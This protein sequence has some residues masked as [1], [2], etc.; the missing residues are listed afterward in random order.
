[1]KKVP[2]GWGYSKINGKEIWTSPTKESQSTDE[3]DPIIEKG[4]DDKGNYYE[5]RKSDQKFLEPLDLELEARN[6]FKQ[7]REIASE[8]KMSDKYRNMIDQDFQEAHLTDSQQGEQAGIRSYNEQVDPVNQALKAGEPLRKFH[9]PEAQKQIDSDA[10]IY[11][12]TKPLEIGPKFE[13]PDLFLEFED[14]D[15]AQSAVD[16]IINGN[17]EAHIQYMTQKTIAKHGPDGAMAKVENNA[18]R[19][20]AGFFSGIFA[21][22]VKPYEIPFAPQEAT[23]GVTSVKG[24][25]PVRYQ[26]GR[27]PVPAKIDYSKMEN[28]GSESREN[29]QNIEG[30][31]ASLPEMAQTQKKALIAKGQAQ[32]DAYSSQYMAE[33]MKQAFLNDYAEKQAQ[34]FWEIAN[35]QYEVPEINPQRVWENKSF[36]S[37]MALIIGSGLMGA[38]GNTAGLQVMQNMVEKDIESQRDRNLNQRSLIAKNYEI[39]RMLGTTHAGAIKSIADSMGKQAAI[40]QQAKLA[41]AN[42][43][44]NVMNSQIQKSM[45]ELNMKLSDMKDKVLGTEK[46]AEAEILQTKVATD[47]MNQEARK[48]NIDIGFREKEASKISNED[49]RR[50]TSAAATHTARKRIA[51]LL[52]MKE[53]SPADKGRLILGKIGLRSDPEM[54]RAMAELGNSLVLMKGR[55]ALSENEMEQFKEEITPKLL[56]AFKKGEYNKFLEQRTSDAIKDALKFEDEI[57]GDQIIKKNYPELQQYRIKKGGAVGASERLKKEAAKIKKGK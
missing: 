9:S 25:E 34:K 13:G 6:K 3:N 55:G 19:K 42:L 21:P 31:Q 37:K 27:V 57:M 4:V 43:D 36:G 53:K 8:K 47:K 30:S 1:V 10:E 48:A 26:G 52:K 44:E 29:L 14:S 18:N 46:G 5:L 39:M 32:Q 16:S 51:E 22:E 33:G 28:I 35:K 23:Q 7:N 54:D 15:D 12:K 11:R 50:L 40:I 24:V 45:T 2:N 20:P 38:G 56:D 17:P 49:D 41:G